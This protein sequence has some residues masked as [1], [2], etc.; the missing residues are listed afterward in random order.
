[1]LD[2]KRQ[3]IKIEN[4]KTQL[5]LLESLQIRHEVWA[6]QLADPEIDNIH[7]EIISLVKQTKQKILSLLEKY[8]Y[9]IPD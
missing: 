4:L 3:E 2:P 6:D 9:H 1:M 8:D 7:L 5:D